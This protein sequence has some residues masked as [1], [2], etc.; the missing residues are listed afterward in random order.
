MKGRNKDEIVNMRNEI[1]CFYTHD[2]KKIDKLELKKNEPHIWKVRWREIS[3]FVE[4]HISVLDY[5]ERK[6]GDKYFY[7]NDRGRYIT[8]KVFCRMLISHYTGVEVDKI[9]FQVDKYGKPHFHL[10]SSEEV[11]FNISHS[12]EWVFLA[13]SLDSKVGIDVEERKERL[14]YERIAKTVFSQ[15][16]YDYLIH[17][18]DIFVFYNIWSAKEA[19]IKWIGQGLSYDLKSFSVIG[20]LEHNEDKTEAQNQLFPIHE[21]GYAGYFMMDNKKIDTTEGGF[22]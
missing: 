2:I 12:G 7:E 9:E 15:E 10:A 11:Y 6:R 19:Y 17:M 5:E 8:G 22:K 21:E 18:D 1:Q 3:D 4:E 20:Q 13:F 14:K 16:E